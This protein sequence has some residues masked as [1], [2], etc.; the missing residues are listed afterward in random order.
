VS[1]T[2]DQFRRLRLGDPGA[3]DMRLDD[4]RL[5]RLLS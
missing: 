4:L 5:A 3:H 1:R 2:G